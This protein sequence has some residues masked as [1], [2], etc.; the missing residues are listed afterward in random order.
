M[1]RILIFSIAFS[2]ATSLVAQTNE[3]IDALNSGMFSIAKLYFSKQLS[4]LAAKPEASYYLGETYRLTNKKDS[5]AYFYDLGAAGEMPNSLCLVGKAG[6]LMSSDTDG[7]EALIKKAKSSKEY[8]KRPSLY[9]AIAKVYAEKKQYDKA[10]ETLNFAKEL[11]KKYTDIYLTEGDILVQL[12]KS[13]D[14]AGKYET[15]IYFDEK[16]KPAYLKVAQI[17]YAAQNNDLALQYVNKVIAIDQHYALAV[18]MYGDISYG[19]GK[20]ASAVYSYAD[21]LK[22]PE[23]VLNDQIRYAY[24][25]FFNKDYGKSVDQINQL[26]P[27]YP[28]NKVLKRI[29]AYNLY[30]TKKYAEGLAQM[31]DFFKVIEPANI[32]PSDYKYYARL[33]SNNEQDSLGAVYFLKA[34]ET[35]D[36]PKEFYKELSSVYRKMKKYEDAAGYMKR[37]LLSADL[38]LNSD[39]FTLG[40]N[41]YFAGGAIDSAAIAADSSKIIERKNLYLSADSVFNEL[42]VKT[43]DNYLGYFW[44]ARVNSILDPES[45]EGLA[46]PHY[47]KVIEILEMKL[48]ESPDKN[49]KN[50]LIESYLYLGYYYYLKEDFVNSK[51]YFNKILAINPDHTVAKQALAGIK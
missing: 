24:A 27:Y 7:A 16:C 39:L 45:T 1:K 6:L 9:V 8:K 21:Y 30:E 2:F 13:G 10:F 34:I 37:H 36:S 28:E 17:Y 4:D 33:L 5:A 23:A 3:G 12:G 11:D 38:A 22:S 42:A 29:L 25:L 46:K 47:E 35:S 31:Q 44:R 49:S 15:A 43:P 14:A 18:K 19:Q 50:Q 26:I 51:I 40:Q 32:L 48:T 41:Y 20:Y